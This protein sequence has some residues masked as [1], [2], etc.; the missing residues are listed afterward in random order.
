MESGQIRKNPRSTLEIVFPYIAVAMIGILIV[1]GV[2][3]F[4]KK[5]EDDPS[6]PPETE[7]T[8]EPTTERE[9]IIPTVPTPP[10]ETEP[11]I[12]AMDQLR[13]S[14][15][16]SRYYE[17]KMNEDVDTLNYIVD[18]DTPFTL[19]DLQKEKLYKLKYDNFN[20]ITLATDSPNFFVSYVAYDL[21]F[22]GI[23]TGAPSLDRFIVRKI[24]EYSYLIYG[25]QYPDSLEAFLKRT[26]GS[27]IV[28]SLQTEVEEKFRAACERDVDLKWL[29]EQ[30]NG[31]SEE[32]SGEASSAATEGTAEP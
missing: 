17:A 8:A 25:R 9:T 31:E 3:L 20:V 4:A 11:E 14:Q 29:M 22:I 26:E 24:D 10:A 23:R 16:I 30:L 7:E 12:S 1:L 15:L 5:G 2:L 19:L 28:K 27:G 6:L 21:Y 13:I 32:P 18:T